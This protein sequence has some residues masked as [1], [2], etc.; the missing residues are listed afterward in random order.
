[1]Y[2]EQIKS[3]KSSYEVFLLWLSKQHQYFSKISKEG[4]EMYAKRF[5]EILKKEK[6][7]N[8]IPQ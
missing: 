5:E 7:E 3:G 6:E 2:T 4:A 8:E 1:M